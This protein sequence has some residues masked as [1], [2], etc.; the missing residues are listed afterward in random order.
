MKVWGEK[1]EGKEHSFNMGGTFVCRPSLLFCCLLNYRLLLDLKAEAF[2]YLSFG[3]EK[4]R[5]P[6]H[7]FLEHF[8]LSEGSY[9]GTFSNIWFFSDRLRVG[10]S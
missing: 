7:P 3:L 1:L 5:K 4:V 9:R 6:Y 10:I 8:R 2:I